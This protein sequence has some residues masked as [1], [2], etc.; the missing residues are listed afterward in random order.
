MKSD[1]HG[2]T[3]SSLE[4]DEMVQGYVVNSGLRSHVCHMPSLEVF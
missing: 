2:F 3:L 4:K 1:S